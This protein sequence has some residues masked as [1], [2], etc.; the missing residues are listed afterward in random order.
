MINSISDR[1]TDVYDGISGLA[2]EQGIGFDDI[3]LVAVSKRQDERKIVS[4]L[5]FGHRVFGENK[6]QDT[7]LKWPALKLRYTGVKLHLIGPL[8]TNKVKDA[9]ILF[10]VIHTLDRPKLALKLKNAIDELEVSPTFYIQLNTGEE[11]QKS[12]IIPSEANDFINYCVHD[13]SLPITGLMCIP[14]ANEPPAPHFA[15]LKKYAKNHHLP[16]LS[17]GMSN[18]Y[19]TAILL[20][21]T[22]LRLGT[23]L[24][25]ERD[26]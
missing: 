12:G 22:T 26:N 16:F 8:Q 14:P 20:G 5:D 2:S 25:G 1:F 7:A 3:T 9:L 21:A 13:L 23:A 24:F 19:D 11:E 10:D 17:M 4:A 15:L 6:I 18:D